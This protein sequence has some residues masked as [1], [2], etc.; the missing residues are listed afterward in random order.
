MTKIRVTKTEDEPIVKKRP[1]GRFKSIINIEDYN[2]ELM[3]NFATKIKI[4]KNK[5]VK[6]KGKLNSNM[7]MF[8]GDENEPDLKTKI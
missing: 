8:K 7:D 6:I 5:K 3:A 2:P 4:K 1:G